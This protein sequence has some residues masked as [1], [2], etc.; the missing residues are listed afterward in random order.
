MYILVGVSAV[1]PVVVKGKGKKRIA[2][3]SS[4]LNAMEVLINDFKIEYASTSRSQCAGCFQMIP[5]GQIRIKKTV[6]DTDIALRFG[7]Q[8]I[9]HHVDCFADAKVRSDVKWY[10]SAEKL[11]GFEM[12]SDDE[13]ATVLEQIP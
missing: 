2:E 9:C 1:I 4:T 10:E 12:L 6:Y 13:K 11:P 8:A 7:S 3:S 5:K